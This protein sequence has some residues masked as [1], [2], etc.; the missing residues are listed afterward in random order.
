ME[1][2]K[3]IMLVL[4]GGNALGSYQAGAYEALATTGF[5]PDRVVGASIG[6]VN[7]AIIAGNPDPQRIPR[8]RALW[9]LDGGADPTHGH[10]PND[11][12]ARTWKAFA[13]GQAAL[14][15]RP[16]LFTRRMPP[17]W[18]RLGADPQAS[19]FDS[20]PLICTLKR[21]VD[22]DYLQRSPCRLTVSAVDLETGED[23]VFN[24]DML[25]L[26]AEHVRASS[27][28]PVL[29]QPVEVEGRLLVDPAM[30]QNL[31]VRVAIGEPPDRDMLCIAIDL[32]DRIG[33]RPA[34]VSHAA[35][36]MQDLLMANQS[37]HAI[38]CLSR[39]YSL[40]DR[41]ARANGRAGKVTLLHLVYSGDHRE[42]A[43]KTLDYS[44][45]SARER[46][47]AGHDDMRDALALL[48]AA[49]DPATHLT[50]HRYSSRQRR[51][52]PDQL[53]C[54]SDAV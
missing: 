4:G 28:L 23:V 44:S 45:A 48:K 41:A 22:F 14:F 10:R 42:S 34:S 47:S 5:H 27:A 2:P 53:S 25:A 18:A 36:R 26:T 8:L 51:Q 54:Q 40:R 29:F 13:A 1:I 24:T 33:E 12:I 20:T 11:E 38:E 7:G 17:P 3:R 39:E 6:A 32:V 30:S 15:G 9:R 50:V 49:P 52:S 16:G 46:W 35:R 19:I 21:L 37:R 31:P 43:A